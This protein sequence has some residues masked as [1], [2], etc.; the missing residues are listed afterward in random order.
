M[1]ASERFSLQVRPKHTN[2]TLNKMKEKHS[3]CKFI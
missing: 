2:Y 1:L 3:K